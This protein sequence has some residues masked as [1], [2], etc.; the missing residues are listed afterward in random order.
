[1][2]GNPGMTSAPESPIA[3]FARSAA[4]TRGPFEATARADAPIRAP[5]PES[6]EDAAAGARLVIRE[7]MSESRDQESEPLVENFDDFPEID[8]GQDDEIQPEDEVQSDEDD[9]ETHGG[10]GFNR[11]E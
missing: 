4:Q 1:M 11:P 2:R 5:E 6:G 3:A 8:S 10:G 7:H 9:V